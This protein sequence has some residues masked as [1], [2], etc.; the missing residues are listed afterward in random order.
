MSDI[1]F[2]LLLFFLLTVSFAAETGLDLSLPKTVEPTTVTSS[3]VV[4]TLTRSGSLY[5]GAS[6]VEWQELDRELAAA[7]EKAEER[8]VVVRGDEGVALGKVVEVMDAARRAGAEG[9]AL[10]AE[11][12]GETEAKPGRAGRGGRR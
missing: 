4:V 2:N 12:K 11:A 10:A 6:E 9:L 8:R 1:I 5:I 7:V 3:E